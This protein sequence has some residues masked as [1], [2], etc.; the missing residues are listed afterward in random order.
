MT[1]QLKLNDWILVRNLIESGKVA[2]K[3]MRMILIHLPEGRTITDVLRDQNV[4]SSSDLEDSQQ[5]VEQQSRRLSE[6]AFADVIKG[7]KLIDRD[8]LKQLLKKQ[9]EG[10]FVSTLGELLEE[11]KLLSE[12]QIAFYQD[13]TLRIVEEAEQ[14]ILDMSESW[15]QTLITGSNESSS[16][17]TFAHFALEEDQGPPAT[18]NPSAEFVYEEPKIYPG[19]ILND[20]YRTMTFIGGGGM[21]AVYKGEEIPSKKTYAIK[22]VRDDLKDSSHYE[23]F[24]REILVASAL[25]HPHIVQVHDA[26]ETNNGVSYFVMDYVPGEGLDSLF[27]KHGALSLKL[28]FQL[29]CQILDGLDY[30]HSKNIV[31]RDL[32]PA[33]LLIYNDDSDNKQLK[34]ADF[35]LARVLNRE[36]REQELGKPIFVTIAGV[37]TGTPAYIAP[38]TIRE[39]AIDHR[40]DLYSVG[41]ILFEMLTGR[42]P[43]PFMTHMAIIAGHLSDAPP[44]LASAS[45]KLFP[46]AIQSFLD[47]LLEKDP[48]DRPQSCQDALTIIKE[49]IFPLLEPDPGQGPREGP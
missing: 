14:E 19:L 34:I 42:K 39:D 32:K 12:P 29:L 43:F 45:N 26:G 8:T 40:A 15:G 1:V 35:G 5:E 22:F 2:E 16:V 13:E 33:N 49:E 46:S 27:R 38:E 28:S 48:D 36:Q 10:S 4:L 11:K 23:R 31:H 41:V 47:S 37:M 6:S 30:V 9:R 21:G 20:Q 7:S 44:K 3:L 24:E 17:N 18:K 25:I